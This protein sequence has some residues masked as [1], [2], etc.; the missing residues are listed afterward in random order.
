MAV[1]SIQ[2]R[3]HD[4]YDVIHNIESFDGLVPDADLL[5][6]L[7]QNRHINNHPSSIHLHTPGFKQVET[8]EYNTCSQSPWPAISITGGECKLMCDH[9]QAEILKPMLNASTAD[10]LWQIVRQQIDLGAQGMLLSGG[11]NHRNEVDFQDYYSTIERIKSHYPWFKIAVHSGLV[12]QQQAN[13][14]KASGVDVAMIDIIGAQETITHVYHLKRSVFDFA[15]SL[16]Y[17]VNSGLSVVPHVVMGLH[18]GEFLGEYN[19]L[20]IISTTD[21]DALVLVAA[22]PQY[23]KPDKP[24]VNP[25]INH[26]AR[27]FMQVREKMINKPVLL[28]CARPSGHTRTLIDMYAVLAG[29]NGIAHPADGIIQFAQD[30]GLK[31]RIESS[32]C[33]VNTVSELE[34]FKQVNP[35][36]KILDEIKVTQIQG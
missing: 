1:D 17:L 3:L 6:L 32:C 12:T 34:L 23:A 28:G 4:W 20:D 22:M 24:F 9:C 5:R 29:L 11:S 19:A 7:A 26:I 2:S 27:F 25:D 14:L 8:A 35:R 31:T 36:T 21:I 16:E 18:Y 13:A 15:Q 10:K 33:S 30:I